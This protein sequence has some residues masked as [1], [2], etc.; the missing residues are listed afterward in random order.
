[1]HRHGQQS[2]FSYIDC[3]INYLLSVTMLFVSFTVRLCYH[4]QVTVLRSGAMAT[5]FTV[6]IISKI[7][8]AKI[9]DLVYYQIVNIRYEA[10]T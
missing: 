4:I 3:Y 5:K 1:M 6:F 10:K 8:D 2:T 9:V 7:K